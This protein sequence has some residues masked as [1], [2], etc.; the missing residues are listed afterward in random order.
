MV[1]AALRHW[2]SFTQGRTRTRRRQDARRLMMRGSELSLNPVKNKLIKERV[3][4]G[5]T[6]TWRRR[7]PALT[8]PQTVGHVSGDVMNYRIRETKSL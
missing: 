8:R 3:P 1:G 7:A 4:L 5:L 6:S 2:R